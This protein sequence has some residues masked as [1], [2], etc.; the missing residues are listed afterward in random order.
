MEALRRSAGQEAAPTKG[1]ELAKKPRK[2][3]AGQ[4]NNADADRGQEAKGNGDEEAGRQAA[5]VSA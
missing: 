4:K 2:A 3:T 1:A 5:E